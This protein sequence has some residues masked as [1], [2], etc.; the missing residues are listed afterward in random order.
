MVALSISALPVQI[1]QDN[2][3]NF[4]SFIFQT[5]FQA[6][7][8]KVFSIWELQSNIRFRNVEDAE[9]VDIRLGWGQFDGKDGVLGEAILPSV[10]PLD[11]V[12]IRFDQEE[13]W[14]TSNEASAGSLNFLTVALH[15]I[16]HSL[17]IGHSEDPTALMFDQYAAGLET[18]T[19][20]DKAAIQSIY[21]SSSKEAINIHRAFNTNAG[22]H[23]FTPSTEEKLVVAA[24]ENF[25][26][27]G[28]GFRALSAEAVSVEGSVPVHRFHNLVTGGHF[29]TS[30][31]LEKII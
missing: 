30:F 18:L 3:K 2:S 8:I 20:D 1:S 4:D 28:V 13:H 14:V 7:V 27:E 21:G 5:S 29:Y 24:M 12:I 17:G 25:V 23:L 31:E 15:E 11:E 10:G 9:N 22:A 26:D 6:D 16:G 19:A